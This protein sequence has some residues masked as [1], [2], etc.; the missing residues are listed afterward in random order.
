MY[1]SRDKFVNITHVLRLIQLFSENHN[2]KLQCYFQNQTNSHNSYNIIHFAARLLEALIKDV[3]AENQLKIS[4]SKLGKIDQC[5][6]TLI[7][8]IQGPCKINQ[9]ELANSKFLDVVKSVLKGDDRM[10]RDL[11]EQQKADQQ[12]L[13]YFNTY[14]FCAG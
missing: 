14:C 8:M 10:D 4:L 13:T 5:F 7:E 1:R 9:Q 6:D 12:V 3:S 11:K 2:Q